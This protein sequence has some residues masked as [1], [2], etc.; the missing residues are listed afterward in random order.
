MPVR[1]TKRKG[2]LEEFDFQKTFEHDI[3]RVVK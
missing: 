3:S 2:K 1:H